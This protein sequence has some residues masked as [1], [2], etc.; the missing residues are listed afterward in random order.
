METRSRIEPQTTQNWRSEPYTSQL[1]LFLAVSDCLWLSA[2]ICNL[3]SFPVIVPMWDQ[4][5]LTNSSFSKKFLWTHR[6]AFRSMKPQNWNALQHTAKESSHTESTM[7]LAPRWKEN[8]FAR[9]LAPFQC[10]L[11]VTVSGQLSCLLPTGSHS[12]ILTV[13]MISA[14]S[15][16]C[17]FCDMPSLNPNSNSMKTTHCPQVKDEETDL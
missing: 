2:L 14:R 13:L 15:V 11:P 3:Y 10:R 17:L 5:F 12:V 6:N 4:A 8:T 7:E 9:G 16:W 1:L